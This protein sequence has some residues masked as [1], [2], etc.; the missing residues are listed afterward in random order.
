[1]RGENPTCAGHVKWL[2]EHMAHSP[3]DRLF[4]LLTEIGF[5]VQLLLVWR[6]SALVRA[7]INSWAVKVLTENR[8]KQLPYWKLAPYFAVYWY[9]RFCSCYRAA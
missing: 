3:M 5:A 6:S 7:G 4:I 8:L 2:L 9:S 1:M